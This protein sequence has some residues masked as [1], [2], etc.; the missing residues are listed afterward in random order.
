M[1]TY[2]RRREENDHLIVFYGDWGTDENLFTPLCGDDFDAIVFYN[3]S[4]D[5]ALVL[6]EKKIYKSVSLIGW[7]LGVWAAEYLFLKTGIIP[8]V[9]IAVNGTPVPAD[10]NYGIPQA[11]FEGTL[12]NVNEKTMNKFHLRMFGNKSTLLEYRNRLPRRTLKSLKEELRWLYNRT[13]EPIDPGIRWDYIVTSAENRVFPVK[14]LTDYWIK[15]P[16]TRHLVVPYPHYVFHKWNSLKD[17]VQF[18]RNNRSVNDIA[19]V[20]AANPESEILDK[21]IHI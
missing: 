20:S 8:D 11:I 7:S 6:P 18:V 1:K 16:A 10:E 12:N 19:K 5:E 13:M 15:R 9:T 4:A 17:F 3:Y 2:I 21:D 14:N